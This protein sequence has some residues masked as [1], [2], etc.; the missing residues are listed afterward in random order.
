MEALGWHKDAR[1]VE[2]VD[3]LLILNRNENIIPAVARLSREQAALYFMLGETQGTSAGGRDEEGKFLRVPGTNPF[4]PLRHEQQGNRFLDLM[5]SCHFAVYL[6]NTGRVGGPDADE[7]S[8]KV[9]I[10]YSSAVV[11]AIAEGTIEWEVDPDFGYEVASA[12]PDVDDAEILQPRKLYERQGRGEEY[13]GIVQRLKE[14][15]RQY[16]TR[17]PGLRPEIVR[18]VA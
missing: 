15:R 14:E 13:A 1:E 2:S 6:L 9:T 8:K 11:K 18:A 4:F 3:H 17:F 12:V 7:R 16:L 5:D 10:P